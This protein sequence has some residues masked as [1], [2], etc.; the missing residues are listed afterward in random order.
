MS[1][2][3]NQYHIYSELADLARP[4]GNAHRLILL[5]HIAQ[6]EKSV[7]KL[8]ELA[9]LTVANTSQHLQQLKRNGYVQTRREG[10]H[11]FYRLG[12]APVVELLMALRQFAEFNH[13]EIRKLVKGTLHHQQDVEAISREELLVRMQE[14]SVTLLDV[15]P[16][17]EFEQGHLPGAINIPLGELEVRLSEL[18]EEQEIVAYCRGPYCSLSITAVNA[19]KEK[20][21][22]ARR[23]NDGVPE[24]KAAGLKVDAL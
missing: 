24:W 12:D 16:E 20:G 17:E 9:D 4:L 19:L 15:R 18:P 14:N 5:E 11:V 6:G 2:I 8:A 21:L 10:K 22:S 3:N 1:T 23:L 13:S 7:E